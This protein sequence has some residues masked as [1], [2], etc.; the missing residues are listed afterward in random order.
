MWRCGTVDQPQ[1]ATPFVHLGEARGDLEQKASVLPARFK[2][3]HA[4]LRILA[5]AR[6]DGTARRAAAGDDEVIALH[7]NSPIP[8]RFLLMRGEFGQE[9]TAYG[10][11]LSSAQASRAGDVNHDAALVRRAAMFEEVDA[12]PGAEHHAPFGDGNGE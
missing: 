9:P 5:Q 6:R 1:L 4:R 2:Q 8:G 10:V 11:P 12:L 3:Q 7:P